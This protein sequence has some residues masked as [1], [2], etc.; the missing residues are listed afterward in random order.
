MGGGGGGCLHRNMKDVVS[1]E[2][3]KRG[4]GFSHRGFLSSVV[5]LYIALKKKN[6]VRYFEHDLNLPGSRLIDFGSE[7]LHGI[8]HAFPSDCMH[9]QKIA[10]DVAAIWSR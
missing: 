7:Y 5:L 3:K 4:W 6:I 9:L 10:V 1:E 2:E 8:W